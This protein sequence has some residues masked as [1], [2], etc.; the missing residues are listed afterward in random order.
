MRLAVLMLAVV[1]TGCSGPAADAVHVIPPAPEPSAPADVA[2]EIGPKPRLFDPDPAGRA[3]RRAARM[4]GY[5]NGPDPILR[6][7]ASGRIQAGTDIEPLVRDNPH[8]LVLRFGDFV[9]ME[10]RHCE[11][12]TRLIAKGG[13]VRV[14]HT[15]DCIYH[16]SFISDQSLDLAEG[17]TEGYSAAWEKLNDAYRALPAVAG[18]PGGRFVVKQPPR[19]P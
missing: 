16:D 4:E 18:V 19:V 7:L 2:P 10:R 12:G 1:L 11:G 6:D 3:A 9:V 14:A 15:G 13:A 17:Y 8:Y 5:R